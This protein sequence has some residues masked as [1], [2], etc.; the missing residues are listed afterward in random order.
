MAK[1]KTV[2]RPT[3]DHVPVP[4]RIHRRANVRLWRLA[5]VLP[6]MPELGVR[7]AGRRPW[8]QIVIRNTPA[9]SVRVR[10][11]TVEVISIIRLHRPIISRPNLFPVSRSVP[12]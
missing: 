1:T 11:R 12:G 2:V 8:I 9:R 5:P 10:N 6:Q 4:D 7:Y 3:P